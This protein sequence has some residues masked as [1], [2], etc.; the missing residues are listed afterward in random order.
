MT[1]ARS[2]ASNPEEEPNK[3]WEITEDLLNETE[4]DIEFVSIAIISLKAQYH[5]VK[6]TFMLGL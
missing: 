4:Q 6:S 1:G 3:L 2:S 5:K